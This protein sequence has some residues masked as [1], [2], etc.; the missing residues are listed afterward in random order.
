LDVLSREV[1]MHRNSLMLLGLLSACV[2]ASGAGR[3]EQTDPRALQGWGEVIDPDGDCKFSVEGEK[4]T[5]AIPGTDHA[6]SVER[7]QMNAPRVLRDVEGD[8]VAQVKV[9]GPF[10]TQ[11][12]GVVPTRRPFHGAGLLLWQDPENFIRLERAELVVPGRNMSYASFELRRGGRFERQGNAA[13]LPV[14]GEELFLR[15]ERRNGL[16]FGS[17]SS[18]GDH[19]TALRPMAVDLPRALRVGIVAGHNTS[20]PFRPRFE[21]FTLSPSAQTE[22]R[23]ADRILK[24]IDT[25]EMPKIPEPSQRGDRAVVMKY[26]ADLQATQARRA[27]LI[28]ELYKVDPANEQLGKLL[29]ERWQAL[30]TGGAEKLDALKAELADVQANARNS[31]LRTEA[32]FYHALIITRAARGDADAVLKAAEAFIQAA[33]KDQRGASLL[34]M[35][36]D[37]T[38]DHEKQAELFRRV[39]KD[40]PGSPVARSAEG[41]LKKF[42]A[43]GKPFELTFNEAITGTEVSMSSLRGKVVV[44]DFW[45]TWCG[46]CVA[47][48]PKMKKLYAEYKD[49]GVEFIGVSLDQPKEQGGLDKLKAFVASNEITWPQYYQGKGW[50]SDFSRSWG[51]NAIPAVFVVNQEGKLYSI[52]ARGKLEEMIPELLKKANTPTEDEDEGGN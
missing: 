46:P 24:E 15:L 32:A 12:Q 28:G 25:L 27:A 9:S 26:L 40:Y 36:A 47:E 14:T 33:P 4:L 2:L 20:T 16:V 52:N 29:P 5:I 18:D 6:L 43:I 22:N 31:A 10:P 49:K 11:A 39:I 42:E 8:F 30:Q 7:G 23:R 37:M 35:V 44:V 34:Y 45:A 1:V 50:E 21:G 48:M 17:V 41:G 19:W 38:G 3:D 13:E 51:I